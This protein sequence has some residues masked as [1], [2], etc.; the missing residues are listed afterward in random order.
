M[1][2]SLFYASIDPVQP[3]PHADLTALY[4]PSPDFL[5]LLP[6]KRLQPLEVA[7]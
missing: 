2:E 6:Y 4:A 1:G 3:P 5:Q 7:A